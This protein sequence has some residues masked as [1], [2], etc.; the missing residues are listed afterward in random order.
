[1]TENIEN[2]SYFSEAQADIV[3]VIDLAIS[4]LKSKYSFYI[5]KNS[6]LNRKSSQITSWI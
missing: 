5:D 1:M 4:C 2:F 3:I 6:K